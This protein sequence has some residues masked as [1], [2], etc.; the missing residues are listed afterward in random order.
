MCYRIRLQRRR[1]LVYCNFGDLI[2]YR[3]ILVIFSLRMRR[4]GYFPSKLHRRIQRARFRTESDIPATGG[5]LADFLMLLP[6]N[7]PYFN[8]RSDLMTFK[9]TYLLHSA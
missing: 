9:T 8:F 5:R 2:T 1:F 4:N 3:M 6:E 7:P